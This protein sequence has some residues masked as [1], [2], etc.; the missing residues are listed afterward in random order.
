MVNTNVELV[1]ETFEVHYIPSLFL[2]KDG[3]VYKMQSYNRSKLGMQEF[4]FEGY[5]NSSIV[6]SYKLPQTISNTTLHIRYV[7]R[8]I[9]N[10]PESL[11]RY[12]DKYVFHPYDLKKELSFNIRLGI[13]GAVIFFGLFLVYSLLSCLLCAK[14]KKVD[15]SASNASKK[16]ASKSSLREKLD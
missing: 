16:P 5:K 2:I 6:E 8:F 7:R 9:E 4:I 14:K 3:M 11:V 10:I 12:A 13:T 15:Q 1:K